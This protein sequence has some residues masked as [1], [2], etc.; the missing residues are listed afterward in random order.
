MQKIVLLLPVLSIFTACVA[1][2]VDSDG[3]AVPIVVQT[4]SPSIIIDGR[5]I[6]KTDPNAPIY[7]C[8]VKPFMETFKSENTNRGKAILDTQKKCLAKNDEM[9]CEVKDIQC[10]EYK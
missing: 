1:P 7:V 3:K 4:P 9:F 8:S 10:T 2:V 6:Q 5:T